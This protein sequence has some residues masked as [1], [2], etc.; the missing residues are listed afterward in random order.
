MSIAELNSLYASAVAAD[1]AADYAGAARY[2]RAILL[3]LGTTPNPTRS[4]GS[5]SQGLTFPGADAIQAFLTRVERLQ[6][7]ATVATGGPFRVS[8][9]TYARATDG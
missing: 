1:L 8:K 9:V 4:L 2:A 3:R 6:K 5:G 7:A